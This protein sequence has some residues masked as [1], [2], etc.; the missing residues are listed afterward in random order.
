VFAAMRTTELGAAAGATPEVSARQ[1]AIR[2]R[3][4]DRIGVRIAAQ[5][6]QRPPALPALRLPTSSF[7]ATAPTATPSRAPAPPS[8]GPGRPVTAS[9][10][11]DHEDG[12]HDDG[13]GLDDDGSSGHGHGSGRGGDNDDRSSGHGRGRGGDDHGDDDRHHGGDD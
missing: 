11:D 8:S 13:H 2:D 3:Q 1:L 6:R 9:H 4:L 7:G 12:H 10:D 5:R